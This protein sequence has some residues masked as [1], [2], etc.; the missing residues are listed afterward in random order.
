[1]LREDLYLHSKVGN[2]AFLDFLDNN[3]DEVESGQ[4]ILFKFLFHTLLLFL[5]IESS[6]FVSWLNSVN[7]ICVQVR[8]RRVNL[9]SFAR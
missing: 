8:V 2:W 3:Y 6:Q 7:Q 5:V 1:M 4:H 9:I